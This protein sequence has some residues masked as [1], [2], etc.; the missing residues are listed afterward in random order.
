MA[1]VHAL[2]QGVW[3]VCPQLLETPLDCSSPG[4]IFCL[5]V[6]GDR[7]FVLNTLQAAADVLEKNMNIYADRPTNIVMASELY[8]PRNIV[9]ARS[10]FLPSNCS[11]GWNRAVALNPAGPQHKRFR[12]LL[13]RSLNS[14]AARAYHPIQEDSARDLARLLLESPQDFVKHI[15]ITV[16]KSM[17]NISYGH[18][19]KVHGRDYIDFAENVHEIFGLHAKPYTFLVDFVPVCT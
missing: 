8:V 6:F 11:I 7:I 1:S 12:G 13:A 4:P 14:T 5:N 19:L 2:E 10:P 9:S 17:V 16:G 18:D 15:R 3:Y